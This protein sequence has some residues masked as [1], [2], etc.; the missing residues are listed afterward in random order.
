MSEKVA[1]FGGTF[2]PP[3]AGH[4]KAFQS[5][6]ESVGPD[7]V[8][9]MPASLPPHKEISAA[10]SPARRF[11]M[12]R[13]A[14]DGI[15]E[16]SVFSALEISRCGK[17]FSVD[18][19]NELVSLHGCE[20]IYM[21]VGSDMLFYFEKWK[22]FETL[23]K[24]CVLVTAPR[25]EEDR[26]EVKAYCERYAKD[27]GCEYMLLP[28][29][30]VDISSTE[31]R[32]FAT[33]SRTEELKKHLTD[34]VY[35]YIMKENPYEKSAGDDIS[36]EK[37]I[38]EIRS[39]LPQ[40]L[41]E[42]R[43][44]H[45]LSVEKCALDMA[46]LFLPHYGYGEEYLRDISAAALLHDITKKRPDEWHREYLSSFMRN[47][48]DHP[49]VFHSWSGAYFALESFFVNPCV[50]RA[51]FNHTTGRAD[52]DVFEKI[53]FLAD[54]IEPG[55]TQAACVSLREKYL[56]LTKYGVTDQ[57]NADEILDSLVL[58]SLCDTF[59]FLDGKGADICPKLFEAKEHL[60]KRSV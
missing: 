46:K 34:D 2:N 13:L 17:S 51:I 10:D 43:L 24:K 1:L 39:L 28:L 36:S 5:F 23:F 57:K 53:I 45:T 59:S 9:V 20:K 21:Y 15:F 40:F 18:T 26:K 55:R 58:Q 3:H 19:V 52:M 35:R 25:C 12:A 16:N 29:V 44:A 47:F 54:Y 38:S 6:C 30:P 27:Y 33:G 50:F 31:I 11:H 32:S 8:Y 22:D 42:K 14:F 7:V 48:G 60:E 4:V 41:G 37:T 49:S 56:E